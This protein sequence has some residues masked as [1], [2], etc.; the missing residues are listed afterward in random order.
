M[1]TFPRNPDINTAPSHAC[2]GPNSYTQYRLREAADREAARADVVRV[3]S[4][5][6][7]VSKC[8]LM[9]TRQGSGKQFLTITG[10][11]G[12]TWGIKD[13]ISDSMHPVLRKLDATWPDVIDAVFGEHADKVR[14]KDWL[15]E[16]ADKR[17]DR[18]APSWP[19]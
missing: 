19:R 18:G 7:F 2:E 1:S 15:V 3:A 13:F 5:G 11:D 4:S 6:S 12:L 14:S 17:N 16:Y 8:L 10:Q 9:I